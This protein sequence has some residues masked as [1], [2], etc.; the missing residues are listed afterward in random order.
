MATK[1]EARALLNEVDRTTGP[2]HLEFPH[3]FDH[4]RALA[5]VGTLI[6]RLNTGFDCR[7]WAD[8]GVQDASFHADITVPAEA[9]A[10]MQQIVIRLSNFGDLAVVAAENLGCYEDLDEAVAEG[11]LTPADRLTAETATTALGYLLVPESA[12]HRSY[13]GV[14]C[15]AEYSAPHAATWWIRFFDYL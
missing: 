2:D 4:H 9:T 11:A 6:E 13:D 14:T 1:T 7:C 3:S 12:L 8:T 5:R 10:A 15:L